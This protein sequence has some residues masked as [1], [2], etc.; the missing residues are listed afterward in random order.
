VTVAALF[1]FKLINTSRDGHRA[2]VS[3][4]VEM[5]ILNQSW[6]EV[7]PGTILSLIEMTEQGLR[8]V[9]HSHGLAPAHI[10]MDT[11]LRTYGCRTIE[12]SEVLPQRLV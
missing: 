10:E 8:S 6:K 1:S 12:V 11:V 9:I 3:V 5:N 2:H 7:I 4:H